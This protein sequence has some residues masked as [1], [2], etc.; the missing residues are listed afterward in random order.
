[1]DSDSRSY[2]TVILILLLLAFFFA[3][4]ET[5]ISS[6]SR[7]KLSAEASRGDRR[8]KKALCVLEDFSKAVT[9]LL[10]CTN[11]V[12]I[13]MASLVTA[14]VTRNWGLS[15]VSLSTV[16]TTI[17]VFFAGEMLPKSIAKK[18]PERF[19]ED[20]AG[21]LLFLM[22]V[23]SPLSN[24]LSG[25]GNFVSEHLS[26]EPEVSVTEEEI[27]DL[28][29]DYTEDGKM[30][31]EQAELLTQALRFARKKVSDIMTVTEEIRAL[32]A[33]LPPEEIFSLLKEENHS[34]IPV[35][36]GSI[37]HITGM[38][39][40][41]KYYRAWYRNRQVPK[42][43]PLLSKVYYT[44]PGT[45]IDD[46]LEKMSAARVTMAVVRERENDGKTLGIVTIEDILEELVGDIYDENDK[47]PQTGK[48]GNA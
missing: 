22:K 30:D 41:R 43:A 45:D 12:H 17:V 44:V 21:V 9:T 31:S 25:I 40:V 47:E 13:L 33:G 32:D 4:C 6:A 36:R 1:M 2:L 7:A 14:Y 42:I 48:G 38:L 3:L 29:E 15:A 11:I 5:A 18:K 19:S 20:T 37:D 28:I 35:Y 23:L 34:R 27:Q 24:I 16:L 8:A 10:I 26:D 46:L 39:S